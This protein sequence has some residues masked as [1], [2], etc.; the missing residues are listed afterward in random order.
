MSYPRLAVAVPMTGM[1]LLLLLSGTVS[2]SG[3][4]DG[5]G[6]GES[7]CSQVSL[8]QSGDIGVDFKEACGGMEATVSGITYDQ[9][10]R[11]TSYNFDFRCT[12]TS[13]RYTGS[14]TDIAYNSLGQALS[15]EVTINGET[16]T[17]D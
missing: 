9:F 16:C 15:A 1:A 2:V 12:T 4:G 6:P 17:F 3:C 7:V 10:G 13:E 11:R 5:S 8:F 14:V